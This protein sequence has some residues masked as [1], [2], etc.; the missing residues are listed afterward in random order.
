MASIDSTEQISNYYNKSFILH[1]CNF[2]TNNF[3]APLSHAKIH[4]DLH[5]IQDYLAQ[6]DIGFA[7][8]NPNK[9]YQ[10]NALLN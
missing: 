3:I 10:Q 4:P 8:S 5:M 9:V 6:S 2:G 1:T 7:L